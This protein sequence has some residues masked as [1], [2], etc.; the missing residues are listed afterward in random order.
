M[1]SP[2][3]ALADDSGTPRRP[4]RVLVVDPQALFGASLASALRADGRFAGADFAADAGDALRRLEASAPDVVVVGGRRA[5]DVLDLTREV[6]RRSPAVKVLALA[7]E[8]SQAHAAACLEAGAHGFLL[9][10]Q[11]LA[12][13]V[14]AVERLGRGEVVCTPRT[15]Y[16]LLRRLAARGDERRR[17]SRLDLLELTPRELD[18]L[19]LLAEGAS[20]AEIAER[21]VLSVHTV[22]NHVHSVLGKLGAT[23][24]WQAVRKASER[25]WLEES[26]GA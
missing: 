2:P 17:R 14:A 8:E 21:L 15:A 7:A 10:Q 24:R 3:A 16:G 6:S 19:R 5:D 18:V 4:L 9:R 25:G 1:R 22:K 20:N 23:T 26:R 11:S 13:L 12:E